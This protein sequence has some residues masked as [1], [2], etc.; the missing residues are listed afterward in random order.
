M[1]IFNESRANRPPILCDIWIIRAIGF[2]DHLSSG[3]IES[4]SLLPHR[5]H[6]LGFNDHPSSGLIERFDLL[7]EAFLF[8][9]SMTIPVR[10]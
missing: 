2:N 1:T 4:I 6:P 8:H 7:L 3:L 5:E 10:G 9:V